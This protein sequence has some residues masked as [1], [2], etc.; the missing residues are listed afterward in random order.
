MVCY[1]HPDRPAAGGCRHCQRG[2]CMECAAL[3]EDTLACRGRHEQQV[4]VAQQAMT[5]MIQQAQRI[6]AGYFRNGIFYGLV[7]AVFVALGIIQ[8]RFLGPQAVF[9]VL[10]GIFL[11]Y[12]AAANFLEARKYR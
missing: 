2:L 10:V 8:Y 5:R 1:F 11:A 12:A 9:F 4:A 7:A 6:G 3:V